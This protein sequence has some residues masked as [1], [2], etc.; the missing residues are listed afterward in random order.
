MKALI[1]RIISLYQKN[2]SL[3]KG[4][5]FLAMTITIICLALLIGKPTVINILTSLTSL[6][7]L[8]KLENN[9]IDRYERV[10]ESYQKVSQLPSSDVATLKNALPDKSSIT[11]YLGSIESMANNNTVRLLSI[12]GKDIPVDISKSS[13]SNLKSFTIT[14]K[15]SGGYQN[16]ESFISNI[17]NIGRVTTLQKAVINNTSSQEKTGDLTATLDLET[18]YLR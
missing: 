12:S 13:L 9:L 15:V 16:I 3:R 11:S 8:R 4:T 7:D 2:E 17:K 5:R 14:A 6:K 1:T 10:N 18:Y